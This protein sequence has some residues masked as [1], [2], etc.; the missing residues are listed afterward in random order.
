MNVSDKLSISIHS[1][2]FFCAEIPTFESLYSSI[3][4]HL[5]D[6]YNISAAQGR[7]STNL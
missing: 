5:V 7:G 6:V 2:F 1:G 3:T 4:A